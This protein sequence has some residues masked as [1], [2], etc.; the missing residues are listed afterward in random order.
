VYS[1]VLTGIIIF[2]IKIVTGLRASEEEEIEGLD[3]SQHGE[4]AYN[5]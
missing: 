4:S 3:G 1:G 5:I 2:V